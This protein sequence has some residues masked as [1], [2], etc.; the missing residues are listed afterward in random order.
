MKQNVVNKKFAKGF[1]LLELL[2]V[3]IIIGI[4]A[5]IAL[6]QYWKVTYKAKFTKV[7]LMLNSIYKAQKAYYAFYG[8]YATTFPSLNMD[9]PKTNGTPTSYAHWDWGY[10]FVYTGDYGGCGFHTSNDGVAR[11]LT[12]WNSNRSSCYATKESDIANEICQAVTG[13]REDQRTSSGSDYVYSFQ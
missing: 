7:T 3:V 10:C 13:K 2:V 6:P 5:A 4:L 1:T 12:W 9:L 8:Q 11:K